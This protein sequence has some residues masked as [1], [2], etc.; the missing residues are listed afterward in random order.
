M[1]KNDSS[2]EFQLAGGPLYWIGNRFHL[3]RNKTDVIR[4]GCMV[5]F[6]IWA[7]QIL[8]SIFDGY[9]GRIFSFSMISFHVSFLLAIPLFFICESAVAPRISI[10]I[11][12]LI[13]S[14]IIP[15]NSIPS[16][17]YT[18]RSIRCLKSSGVI[19][20]LL[21]CVA[22]LLPMLSCLPQVSHI[23]PKWDAPALKTYGDAGIAFMVYTWFCQPF[24]RFLVIRWLWHLCL[25]WYL[26]WRIKTLNLNLIP[27]HPDKMAGLGYIEVVQVNFLLLIFAFS[28]V[29][30]ARFAENILAGIFGFEKLHFFI[31]LLFILMATLFIA[32]FL[33]FS[34]KLLLCRADGLSTYMGV[35]SRY[36]GAFDDK[37]IQNKNYGNEQLLGSP[38][39]QALSDLI[40]SMNVVKSMHVFPVGKRFIINMA[41]AT[42]IPL[43]PL[44]FLKYPLDELIIQIVKMVF[45]M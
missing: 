38:D 22:Y 37:W 29:F 16:I 26:L 34:R 45:G 10:F 7:F 6:C 18:I 30:S 21:L 9:A 31:P 43:V 27:I 15:E 32:P 13:N 19:E 5:S 12:D 28:S 39:I 11:R 44:L 33:M 8:L 24:F 42:G 2:E 14:R 20:L 1:V 3:V 4:F 40:N 36:I 41:M 17:R 23:A 35:A 25:W